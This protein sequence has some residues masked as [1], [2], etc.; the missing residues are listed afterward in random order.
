MSAQDYKEAERYFQTVL[1]LGKLL[2]RDPEPAIALVRFA[3]VSDSIKALDEMVILYTQ[4]NQTKK[5]QTAQKELQ[6]L[7][8]VF[9][10]GLGRPAPE[11]H[12]Q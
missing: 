11:A 5:L 9:L 10:P 6:E 4:T 7:P 2:L 8:L 3:G 12:N 1:Q